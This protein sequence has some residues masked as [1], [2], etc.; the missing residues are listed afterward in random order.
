MAGAASTLLDRVR[1]F[2]DQF[3]M[4][5][6]GDT[7][8]AAVSGG[9]D[10]VCLLDV[11]VELGYG[12]EVAHFDHQTRGMESAEDAAFVEAL[13]RRHGVPYHC[14]RRPIHEEAEASPMSFEE[15]A[16][17]A[18]Y[19]F[20]LAVAQ[21]RGCAAI[22]T[23]HHADDQ[24]ETVLMRVVRGASPSGLAGI[25]PV[26]ALETVRVIRPLLTSTRESILAC[27]RERGL[28]YR[29]DSSND[30]NVHVRNRVRTD[31]LPFLER[32]YNPRV[33]EALTRL[34]ELQRAENDY[35]AAQ[36]KALLNACVSEE[37]M[38]RRIF[39]E[40][41]IALQRR[42][43]AELAWQHDI[44]CEFERIEPARQFVVDGAAGAS[45]DF[46]GGVLLRNARDVTEIIG[47]A[48]P[49]DS[50][51]IRL[52][53][54]GET[55][56][57]GKR[58]TASFLASA[59]DAP[60]HAYCHSGRQVFDADE[61][62]PALWVRLRRQ[63]DRITPLGMSG[64]RKLKDYFGD[65]G[66]PIGERDRLPL[67]VSEESI[68]WIVGHA[69]SAKAAITAHTRRYLEIEVRNAT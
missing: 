24:A 4:I 27:L 59:P 22:A 12:V 30:H 21:A 47:N 68:V 61:V 8:L 64:S 63:G 37:T 42:A 67:I 36:A 66:L 39:S 50:R 10:S 53:L 41:P 9:P 34:A 7:V 11:L 2:L 62:G 25:P 54:P 17:G 1:L 5:D 13:A 45:F 65:L 33:R 23:G 18:R 32:E 15:Y 43:L 16:R 49:S 14:E 35:M 38:K 28:P 6:A 57:F 55:I 3:Q 51:A 60:L 19:A 20:L 52:T 31:L 48:E 44:N 26:R 56:A 58:F 69:V 46:G 29:T 40:A